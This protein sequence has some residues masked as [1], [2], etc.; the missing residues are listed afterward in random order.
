[1]EIPK[2]TG[3]HFQTEVTGAGRPVLLEFYQEGCQAC[4]AQL[5]ILDQAAEEACDVKFCRVDAGEEPELAD[6]YGV[7][8]FPAMLI[9]NGEKI[10]RKVT[11]RQTLETVLEYLEM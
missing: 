1:M 3:D 8:E 4:E 2:I 6:R 7:T 5:P 11:G 10:F 9:L